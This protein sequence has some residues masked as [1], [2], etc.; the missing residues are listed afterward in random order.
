MK[1]CDRW[2]RTGSSIAVVALLTIIMIVPAFA[3]PPVSLL[4]EK[5]KQYYYGEKR[6]QSY[7]KALEL[8]LRAAKLGDAESQFISGGMYY[9]GLGS[10]KNIPKAFALLHEAAVNGKSNNVSQKIIAEEFMRGVVI[11]QNP[12]KALK[13]YSLAAKNGNQDAQNELAYM[14]YTGNGVPQDLEKGAE[15]FLESAYNGSSTAQYN[16]GLIYYSGEGFGE[17]DLK[18]AYAWIAIAASNGNQQA[19]GAL[20]YLK[21]TLTEAELL[22]AQEHG[23]RLWEQLSK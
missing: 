14:Y 4:K 20:N 6:D 23:Y 13:W 17:V 12:E 1:I 10:A 19:L 5:A 22:V 18:S 11:P 2:G 21:T 3:E 7:S 8:Y 15:L 16:I 9:K